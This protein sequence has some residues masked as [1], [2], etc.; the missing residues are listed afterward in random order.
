[1]YTAGRR[2][3]PKLDAVIQFLVEKFAASPWKM[4]GKPPARSVRP[5]PFGQATRQE[6]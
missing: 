4:T 5:A 2:R 1:V 3:P 6:T